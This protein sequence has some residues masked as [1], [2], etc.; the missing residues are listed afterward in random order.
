MPAGCHL[1]LV[2][3]RAQKKNRRRRSERQREREREIETAREKE[4]RRER[5]RERERWRESCQTDPAIRTPKPEP[6]PTPKPA[7]NNPEPEDLRYNLSPMRCKSTTPKAEP[8]N[9]PKAYCL[10]PRVKHTEA[11]SPTPKVFRRVACEVPRQSAS[12]RTISALA[13]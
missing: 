2:T 7:T 6:K 9:H 3:L 10:S 13:K 1:P 12:G 4:R 11:Q 5:E 8:P